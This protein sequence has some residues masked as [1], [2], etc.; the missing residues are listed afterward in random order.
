MLDIETI[1]KALDDS[2]K[3]EDDI[4][5]LS[6]LSFFRED[7]SFVFEGYTFTLVEQHGGEGSGDDYWMVFSVSKDDEK[8]YFKIPGYYSSDCGCILC[9]RKTVEVKPIQKT[10]TVW[11]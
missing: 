8:S 2:H 9:W 3:V 5:M 10:I 11:G 1:R 6:G 4:Y 7:L